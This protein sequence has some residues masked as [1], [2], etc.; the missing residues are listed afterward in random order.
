MYHARN[1]CYRHT[2][3]A[4]EAPTDIKRETGYSERRVSL[5]GQ[6]VGHSMTH[7][8]VKTVVHSMG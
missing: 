1:G 3:I 6:F 2:R 7:T 4:A 8:V 5:M